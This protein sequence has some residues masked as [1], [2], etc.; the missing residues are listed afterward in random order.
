[1]AGICE[2]CNGNKTAFGAY[3]ERETGKGD[4]N[5]SF[6]FGFVV[7]LIIIAVIMGM[8]SGGP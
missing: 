6:T 3:L 7:V 4:D 8:C 5:G 1:M 2:H